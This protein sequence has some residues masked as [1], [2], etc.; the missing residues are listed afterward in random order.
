MVVSLLTEKA[1]KH[2]MIILF[3]V[4]GIAFTGVRWL[5]FEADPVLPEDTA[6][7]ISLKGQI[8]ADKDITVIHSGKPKS[9]RYHKVI[10]QSFYHPGLKVL[11]AKPEETGS[12]RMRATT[13]GIIELLVEYHVQVS[14]T[15]KLQVGDKPALS[16]EKRALY[17]G[18]NENVDI[19]FPALLALSDRLQNDAANKPQLLHNIFLHSQNLVKVKHPRF[20]EIKAAIASNKAT[21]LGR[22]RLM[23][24]LCR[25]SSIP[26]RLVTGFLLE[27]NNAAAPYY[28]V[29]VYDE[30]KQWL[31]YDPEKGYEAEVPNTHVALRY[32]RPDSFTI[33]DGKLIAVKY[34]VE[35]DIDALSV[36]R[37]E[38]EKNIFDIFDLRRLDIDTRQTLIKLLILPI[39]I[40]LTAFFRH[41]LGLYPY[42]VFTAPLLA[43][44][45]VYAEPLITL[46]IAGVVIFLALLGRS[47]LPKTLSRSP[48]LSLV[49]TFVAISMAFSVSLLSYFSIDPGGS[50][51]LI[52]TIILASIVDRFY[53]YMDESG[54]HAALLRLGVTVLIAIV[55]IPILINEALGA[56]LLAYP[57]L[58]L[59]TAALVLMLSQYKGIKLTDHRYL[60][61]LG[62]NKPQK[63]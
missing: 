58:H 43:L 39:C 17:L 28:W 40:L 29:E 57:E 50:I 46:V 14:P 20:D 62:E 15:P 18:S 1:T 37:F 61:L 12:I 9:G 38:Q 27:E 54:T 47:I 10:S 51:I 30:D 45:M 56:L 42:G 25:A 34:S 48:R 16:A 35:E 3:A 11:S 44:A 33:D 4:V 24:A 19:T 52:P 31:S 49:F 41:V 59:V 5:Y 13:S 36:A 26:A 32:D 7:K 6:W 53:S 63:H 2:L 55:C 22:A 8:E 60:R 23:V 21:T